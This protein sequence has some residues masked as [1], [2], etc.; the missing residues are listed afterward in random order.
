[1]KREGGS[2][3]WLSQPLSYRHSGLGVLRAEVALLHRNIVVR[4]V[5]EAAPYDWEGE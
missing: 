2:R 1:M 5:N 4:G 3:I